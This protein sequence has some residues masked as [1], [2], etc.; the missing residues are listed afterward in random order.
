LQ[1]GFTF[2]VFFILELWTDFIKFSIRKTPYSASRTCQLIIAMKE[3]KIS[4][5]MEA[6]STLHQYETSPPHRIL[7]VED[8]SDIRQINAMVLHQAGY[9]VDTAEDGASGWN[10]LKASRYDVLITDN[11]MP[12]VTGMELIKK[13]RSEEMTLSVI[14]ASGTVPTEELEQNPWLKLDA[15]LIKPYTVEAILNSVKKVLDEADV[16]RLSG[17]LDMI[18]NKIPQAG[19][20]V[21]APV[22]S[23]TSPA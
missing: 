16:S 11:N 19:G 8:D 9:Y 14:L 20:P 17:S 7:M 10:A 23:R 12:R 18:N 3:N 21:S 2:I 4:Q 1:A 22:Q 13:L 6:V 15:V 5:T